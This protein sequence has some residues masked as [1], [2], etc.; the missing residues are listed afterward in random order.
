MASYRPK[1]LDELNNMYD[2]T[3]SAEQ[4]IKKGTTK[5]KNESGVS[6]DPVESVKV[7]DIPTVPD[8]I[9]DSATDKEIE[10]LSFAV[11]NFIRH[12]SGEPAKPAAPAP[13][14]PKTPIRPQNQHKPNAQMIQK[15]LNAS[16]IPEEGD[17]SGLMNEY[18]KIMNDEDDEPL[19]GKRSRHRKKD[20]KKSHSTIEEAPAQAEAQPEPEAEIQLSESP[21][22]QPEPQQ[23]AIEVP[24]QEEAVRS[25]DEEE[26]Y[27]PTYYDY[28]YDEAEEAAKRA[29]R[30]AAKKAEKEARKAAKKAAKKASEQATIEEHV[31][32]EE[33]TVAEEVQEENLEAAFEKF[34]EE[35]ETEE[36][37]ARSST[38]R[39]V[40]RTILSIIFV[41]CLAVTAVVASMNLVL[42]INTGKK[43]PGDF[44]FFTASYD[45]EDADIK[46]NDFIIC[47]S[48]T[49]LIDGAKAAFIYTDTEDSQKK[50]AFGVKNGGMTDDDG[51]VVYL[52]GNQQIARGD[53]L[54][55]IEKT[56][57]SIG[58]I[59]DIIF[60]YYLI[61]IVA[62]AALT[63]LL[64]ILVT[65]VL[66]NKDKA[67]IKAQKKEAKKQKKI[68]A[69]TEDYDEKLE[70]ELPSQADDAEFSD[71]F[72]SSG[73]YN[74]LFND[75]D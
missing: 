70:E 39:I 42:N 55:T 5:L 66:R 45:Y 1:S 8:I 35:D 48:S 51:N 28:D 29:E 49:Y 11:D 68:A 31:P 23:P 59:V 54:G 4:A 71:D 56:F 44:Y 7:T 36:V 40:L 69:E 57:P 26:A 6:V 30:K 15:E 9:K 32:V 63:I 27:A 17:L 47:K 61:F 50:V 13:S 34:E 20:R 14:Y 12:F 74:N 10:D 33:P 64:F 62:L 24:I 25:S 58:K 38:G 2:K 65:L 3:L 60:D 37:Q 18:I 43:A 46:A 19:F 21:S 22:V 67:I 16:T 41:I 72:N 52:I 53:A 73:N 75:I